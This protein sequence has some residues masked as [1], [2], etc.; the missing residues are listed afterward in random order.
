MV[1]FLAKIER[2]V[3]KGNHTHVGVR[4]C[5]LV[6]CDAGS[7]LEPSV[8]STNATMKTP[9]LRLVVT[10]PSVRTWL[11]FAPRNMEPDARYGPGPFKRRMVQARTPL[12]VR[13]HVN[14]WEGI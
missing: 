5:L 12:N 11:P 10:V 6:Q 4:Y 8:M 2:G 7:I 9:T 1:V 13:C 14:W 3:P